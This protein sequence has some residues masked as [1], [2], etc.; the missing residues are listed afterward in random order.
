MFL[1]DKV[2]KNGPSEIRGRQPLKKL[3]RYGLLRQTISQYHFKCFKGCLQEIVLDPLLNILSHI[4]FPDL[5][6]GD[7]YISFL[8]LYKRI[9]KDFH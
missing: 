5:V 8:F 9:S 1:W 3:K 7:L 6:R 2:F 4:F